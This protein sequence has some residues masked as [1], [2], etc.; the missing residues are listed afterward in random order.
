VLGSV[1]RVDAIGVGHNFALHLRDHRFRVDM[2]NVAVPCEGQ[3]QRGVNDPAQRFV[4]LKTCFYQPL[5]DG[6]ERNQ[7][8]GLTDE[9]TIGQLSG[10]LYEIDARRTDED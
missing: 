8:E 7:V 9:D 4:N 1:V 6:F 5:A 2:V 3:P 10:V